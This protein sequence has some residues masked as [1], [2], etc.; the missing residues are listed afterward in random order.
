MLWTL[1]Y[2]S[3]TYYYFMPSDVGSHI[4]STVHCCFTATETVRLIR[5]E[6]PGRPPRPL[7]SSWPLTRGRRL[8][9]SLYQGTNC[10]CVL[11]VTR[12][13]RGLTAIRGTNSS[14]LT[15]RVSRCVT[16]F[17]RQLWSSG[18][19]RWLAK[20]RA[21]CPP[22]FFYGWKSQLNRNCIMVST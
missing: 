19:W 16:F 6:S 11:A 5:T 7:H 4:L 9:G 12:R 10:V 20:D 2:R 22:A 14:V 17:H 15:H 13:V 21:Q 18:V 8:E 3:V 1:R